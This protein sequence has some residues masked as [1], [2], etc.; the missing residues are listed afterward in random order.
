MKIHE[1]RDRVSSLA[2]NLPDESDSEWLVAVYL[3]LATAEELGYEKD[4]HAL[5][6]REERDARNSGMLCQDSLR[7]IQFSEPADAQKE[8]TAGYYF[9][10]AL[11]RM[12]A[13]AEI[14]L[15]TLFKREMGLEPP[16]MRYGWLADWYKIRFAGTLDKI[17]NA[18][19][20]VNRFKHEDRLGSRPKA[21]ALEKYDD[22]LEALNELLALLTTIAAKPNG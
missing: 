16:F 4:L 14:T 21:K 7:P 6:K 18:R 20:R 5:R 15:Q 3:S 1:Y 12:V 22:A 10:N 8:W 13:L 11:F 17:A 19:T 9:N 2:K